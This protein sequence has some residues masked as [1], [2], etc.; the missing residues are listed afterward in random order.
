MYRPWREP[1]LQKAFVT[2]APL[3]PEF[4]PPYGWRYQQKPVP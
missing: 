2:F 3:L 1:A 4:S